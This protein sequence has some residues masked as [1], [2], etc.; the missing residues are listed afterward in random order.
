VVFRQL[1]VDG[2]EALQGARLLGRQT[3][4]PAVGGGLPEVDHRAGVVDLRCPGHVGGPGRHPG[5]GA[6]LLRVGVGHCR[7][8]VPERH[9]SERLLE[10][11]EHDAQALVERDVGAGGV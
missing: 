2:V 9:V 3:R 1:E 5:G 11:V 10:I 8:A 7:N 4:V 6:V